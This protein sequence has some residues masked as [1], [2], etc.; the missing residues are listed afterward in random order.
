LSSTA[1]VF[2]KS[3]PEKKYWITTHRTVEKTICLPVALKQ[4]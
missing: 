1:F 2:I 4:A 3:E